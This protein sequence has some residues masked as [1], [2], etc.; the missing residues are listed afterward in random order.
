SEGKSAIGS[1]QYNSKASTT[2]TKDMDHYIKKTCQ[3]ISDKYEDLVE[4]KFTGETPMVEDM[5]TASRED[6]EGKEVYTIP[7]ALAVL[8]V[9]VGTWRTIVMRPVAEYGFTVNPFAPSLMMSVTIAMSIDYS[10][11]LLTRFR[12]EIEKQQSQ[13]KKLDELDVSF[14]I[15]QVTRWSGKVVLF[16]GFILMITYVGLIAYPMTMLQSI[17]LGTSIAVLC[18]I[19]INLTLTPAILFTFPDF[20]KVLG[21]HLPVTCVDFL[22]RHGIHLQSKP[23][24]KYEHFISSFIYFFGG[25]GGKVYTYLYIYIH[26]ICV[27]ENSA[28]NNR[29]LVVSAPS[30]KHEEEEKVVMEQKP[31]KTGEE[32]DALLAAEEHR[33]V[34]DAIHPVDDVHPFEITKEERAN[35]CNHCWYEC[36][37]YATIWPYTLIIVVV[38]YALIAPVGWRIM[39]LRKQLDDTLTFPRNSDYLATFKD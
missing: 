7:L 25:G 36:G 35:L 11:F 27:D 20:F 37:S 24:D 19:A 6:V 38:V 39:E 3:R 14:A 30:D 1:I 12:E 23:A 5:T 8:A 16:S 29:D 17:G 15:R 22:A 9:V 4:V 31:T 32:A 26:Y 34:K 10:L 18:T 2:K 13:G 33:R 21:C 28:N